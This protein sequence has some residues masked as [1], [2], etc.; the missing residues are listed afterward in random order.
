MPV[1]QIKF[2]NLA[3]NKIRLDTCLVDHLGWTK[4]KVQ[5]HIKNG[6]VQVNQNVV[7]KSGFILDQSDYQI[8]IKPID[9]LITSEQTNQD[10]KWSDLWNK[11]IIVYQD[12]HL[13]IINKP[14]GI[15][16]H[17]TIKNENDTITDFLSFYWQQQKNQIN[18]LRNGLSHRLDK[19]TSGLMIVAKT[20]LALKQILAD[21]AT[22]KIVK[23]YYAI[24]QG[25]LPAK[26]IK[27]NLPIGRSNNGTLKMR[28]NATKDLKEAI[29]EVS[30]IEALH[31]HTLVE[32]NLLTGRTHQIRVHLAH[33]NHPV[34]NDYLYGHKIVNDPFGQYLHAGYIQLNH[35]ITK[36]KLVFQVAWPEEFEAKYQQLR[37]KEI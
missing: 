21:F 24:V 12:D 28:V 22:K 13:L 3:K 16:S 35:P 18:L 29:T 36:Q 20:E 8:E 1:H 9:W 25:K 14:S 32:C 10:L 6:C 23:K 37:F 19:E 7:L 26:K 30:E 31:N 34:L 33:I 15:L 27:I 2:Q 5:K 11:I 17:P 4:T